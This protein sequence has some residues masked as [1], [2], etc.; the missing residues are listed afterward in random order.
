MTKERII[1]LLL[2]LSVSLLSLIC[3]YVFLKIAPIWQ[4]ILNLFFT[5]FIPFFIAAFITYLLH[6]IV[7]KLHDRGVPRP[8][9]ILLIYLCFFGGVGYAL[10]KGVPY[11]IAQLKDFSENIPVYMKI[12]RQWI[13]AFYESTDNLPDS[14]QERIMERLQ[15]TETYLDE[16][17]NT[18]IASIKGIFGSLVIIT[19]IPFVV[20]YLLKDYPL[21]E[22]MAWYFT[23]RK[24][25]KSLRRLLRDINHSLGSYIRGQLIVCLLIGVLATIAL[26]IAKV[27]YPVLLGII[28]GITNIIPY[29]GPI[30]G[31]VPAVILAITISI[32]KVFIVVG[33]IFA[34]QFIE[35]NL[36][37][38]LI[39]GKSLHMHPVLIIFSLLLGGEIG[40][41]VGLI[42]AVPFLAVIKVIVQH[43]TIHF[44]KN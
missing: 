9:S 40:G 44:Q 32:N 20:F 24:W 2:Y 33:I 5:I 14:F 42:L 41:I 34:L 16:F 8:I 28:I 23:P 15:G 18:I 27:P 12:Y 39:V 11:I 3:I 19:V 30:L 6:P 29:F 35:G 7:E 43:T 26:W 36:L 1:Q 31:A 17:I 4:P 13:A 10:F 25:R 38:P 22:K 21:V 37:S